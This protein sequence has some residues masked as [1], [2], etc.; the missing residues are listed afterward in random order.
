M[1]QLIKGLPIKTPLHKRAMKK[2]YD[3]R[4]VRHTKGVAFLT[5][6][7]LEHSFSIMPIW[8]YF[9]DLTPRRP[10][11]GAVTQ[12]QLKTNEKKQ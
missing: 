1:A 6:S 2:E 7:L 4:N 8:E 12:A 3:I 5:L 9:I 11:A 10:W